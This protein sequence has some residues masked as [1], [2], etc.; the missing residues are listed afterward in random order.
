[1]IAN[2]AVRLQMP[3]RCVEWDD[4]RARVLRVPILVGAVARGWP[5]GTTVGSLK[6]PRRRNH[7]NHSSCLQVR[8]A[9]FPK[10]QRNR[11]D[12]QRTGLAK[13]QDNSPLRW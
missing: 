11:N 10:T 12:D 3:A 7:D 8:L 1:M 4:P 9:G 5:V 13:A 2:D 6:G